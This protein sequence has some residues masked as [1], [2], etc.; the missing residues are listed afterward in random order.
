MENID[1]IKQKINELVEKLNQYNSQYYLF[2]NPS[3]SDF[4]YDELF[5]ELQNLELQNPELILEN[6]PTQNV[7]AKIDNRFAE[8]KHIKPMLSLN[9]ALEA[10]DTEHFVNQCIKLTEQQNLVFTCE[11][12]FDG[13]AISLHYRKGKLVC[14][15]TRGDGKIGEDVTHNVLTINKIPQQLNDKNPPEFIEI[16]G[17]ILIFTQDFVNLNQKQQA[18]GK[19]IYV[20]PRNAAA[21]SLRQLEASNTANIPLSFFAYGIG[22]VEHNLENNNTNSNH[23]TNF[24]YQHEILQKLKE[25]GL[26][27]ADEYIEVVEGFNGLIEYYNNI[28]NQ[29]ENL[30]FDIDGVVYKI[31]DLFLQQEMGFVAKAPRFAIAHKFPP[32]HAITKLLNIEVQVGR[33]GAI[34]PVA[35]LEPVMVGGV[36]ISNATLHNEDE[37]LRKDIC[38]NDDVYIRRA[39]DVIPEVFALHA[40]A[41]NRIKFTMPTNCPECNSIIVKLEGEAIARC[42]GNSICPAQ[43]KGGLVHFASRKALNIEGFGEK[44]VNQLVDLNIVNKISDIFTLN[45]ETLE[46][47]DRMGKKSAQNLVNEIEKAKTNVNLAKFIYALGIRHVGETTAKDLARFFGNFDAIKNASTEQL[48]QVQD[49]GEVVANSLKLYFETTPQQWFDD[50]LQHINFEQIINDNSS[51][52]NNSFFAQKTIVITGTLEKYGRDELTQLLEK[53]GAKVTSS[54]SKKTDILIAGSEA[55]SKLEKATSLGIQIM[56]EEEL[57]E[58]L[59]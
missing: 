57:L 29:R 33:T 58:K 11:P 38:I 18:Q 23:S 25:W 54:V 12:K 16:R 46:N 7:G 59:A 1:N 53:M 43:R 8:V 21:G 4:D 30:P 32:R 48:L 22:I 35:R 49:I 55:G 51:M 42:S 44:I 34:T 6:S 26:P 3:I 14:A 41:E 45:V 20:N 28:Q 9:N 2:D 27:L 50:L 13:L 31:N 19:R 5:R 17:E 37:I 52:Q 39:A 15:A 10:S 40:K 56:H 36:T 47:L 24:K